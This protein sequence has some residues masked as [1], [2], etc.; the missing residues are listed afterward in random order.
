[1]PPCRV[2]ER[3][4]ESLR[5]V[6]LRLTLGPLQHGGRRDPRMQVGAREAWRA[7]R[8]ADGPATL[9]LR[10]ISPTTVLAHAWGAGAE[11]ALEAAP[12]LIGADDDPPPLPRAHPLVTD[13]DRRHP[14][15]RVGRSRAVFDELVPIVLAQR[16]IGAEASFA[17]R[18]M[19][20][21][22]AD[23]APPPSGEDPRA[24]EATPVH[25]RLLLPPDPSWLVSTGTWDFHRWGVEETR[26][27]TIKN[28]AH[29]AH[30]LDETA[31]MAFADARR[32]LHAL[33]GVGP[34]TVNEVAMAA[35]G[36]PDAV[37]VG[38]YWLK[39][40]VSNALAGEPRGTDERMLELLE[41]WRGQRGRVCRLLR[42][43]GPPLPRFGPRL[44]LR[45]IARH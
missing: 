20:R 8:T 16:V 44:P 9:R 25:P 32:R 12:E 7:T 5:P 28:A 34:W 30:R 2:R 42:R 43:G 38:D 24:H 35:L 15:L 3:I 40:V 31:D 26:A 11:A 23:P 37:S 17:Y 18:A 14:G 13:L 22:A 29:Y 36:D 41:P 21:A 4:I 39:H 19:T 33:P 27:R 10:S 1:M 6:D 45:R